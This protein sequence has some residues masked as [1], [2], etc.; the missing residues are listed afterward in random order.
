[1]CYNNAVVYWRGSAFEKEISVLQRRL[2]RFV[3]NILF[4]DR[5]LPA[6]KDD[7]KCIRYFKISVNSQHI[8]IRFS[9]LI[10]NYQGIK[11]TEN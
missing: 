8:A 9:L 11:M 5:P 2:V 4:I 7:H 3:S 6:I 1:M 10:E